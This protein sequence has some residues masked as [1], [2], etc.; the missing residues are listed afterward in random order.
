MLCLQIIRVVTEEAGR[1]MG[2]WVAAER[3]RVAQ[4]SREV[5]EE[6]EFQD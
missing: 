1:Q 4:I 6:R 3:V 2:Q 5:R